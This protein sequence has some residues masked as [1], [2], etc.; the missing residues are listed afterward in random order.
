M[1]RLI[2]REDQFLSRVCT[3]AIK[4][5][6]FIKVV[7]RKY[8]V[9]TYLYTFLSLKLYWLLSWSSNLKRNYRTKQ[10]FFSFAFLF[11]SCLNLFVIVPNFFVIQSITMFFNHFQ[12]SLTIQANYVQSFRMQPYGFQLSHFNLDCIQTI[13]KDTRMGAYVDFHKMCFI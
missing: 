13:Y 1:S 7:W 9:I 5:L 3:F 6:F 10:P 11:Y 2:Y 4:I 8:R 12:V